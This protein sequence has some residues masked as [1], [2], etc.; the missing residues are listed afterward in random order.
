MQE[1]HINRFHQSHTNSSQLGAYKQPI[2]HSSELK[3]HEVLL[4]DYIHFKI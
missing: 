1:T 3:D 2:G 4:N